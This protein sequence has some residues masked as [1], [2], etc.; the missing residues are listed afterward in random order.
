MFLYTSWRALIPSI[1]PIGISFVA[2]S[3]WPGLLGS[4][5]F[6]LFAFFHSLFSAH[7][8]YI[9]IHDDETIIK[10]S[11]GIA[12]K[13]KNK[14]LQVYYFKRQAFWLSLFFQYGQYKEIISRYEFSRKD[15]E[16]IISELEKKF[17]IGNQGNRLD[18]F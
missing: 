1:L 15:W 14:E 18:V 11:D 7:S 12:T 10:R 2:Q 16:V 4:L 5:L 3:I 6:I 9:E 8:S 13:M 17:K